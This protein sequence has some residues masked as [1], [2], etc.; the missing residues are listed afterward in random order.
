[1]SDW[2]PDKLTPAEAI[3]MLGTLSTWDSDDA[4][5]RADSI[6]LAVLRSNGLDAVADVFL[7]ADDRTTFWYS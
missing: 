4:H 3:A 5:R 7:A 2:V 1:M 6:L